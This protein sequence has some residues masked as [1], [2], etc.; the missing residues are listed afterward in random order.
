MLSG[1]RWEPRARRVRGGGRLLRALSTLTAVAIETSN[2]ALP[3]PKQGGAPLPHTLKLRIG[4]VL[5]KAR[6]RVAGRPALLRWLLSCRIGG[7][8]KLASPKITQPQRYCRP[9]RPY[10]ERT[11]ARGRAM[12][13]AAALRVCLLLLGSQVG[14]GL[15]PVHVRGAL[16]AVG[17]AGLTHGPFRQL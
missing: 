4:G 10:L 15:P 7:T 5:A 13:T 16:I 11:Y 8:T 1:L 3:H 9:G 2:P 12:P 17:V 6:H 14:Q